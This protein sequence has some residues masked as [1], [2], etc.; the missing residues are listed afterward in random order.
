VVSIV[1]P[2][3]IEKNRTKFQWGGAQRE[4]CFATSEAEESLLINPRARRDTGPWPVKKIA[5]LFATGAVVFNAMAVVRWGR[6][7][8]VGCFDFLSELGCPELLL[9]ALFPAWRR[10]HVRLLQLLHSTQIR[11]C[12]HR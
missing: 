12:V 8:G 4:G 2:A 1:G 6:A 11:G 7:S 9:C 5:V 10:L 3:K